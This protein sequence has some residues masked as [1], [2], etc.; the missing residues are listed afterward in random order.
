MT[1]AVS[2][3]DVAE[4]VGSTIRV[5][6]LGEADLRN[7]WASRGFSAAGRVVLKQRLPR[8]WRMAAVEL[9]LASAT[10]R[11]NEV[12]SRSNA[13]HLFSDHWPVRRWTAAWVAEQKTSSEPD[14]MFEQLEIATLD[15][16]EEQLRLLHPKAEVEPAQGA[17]CVGGIEKAALGNPATIAAAAREL[18]NAYVGRD[19]FVVP[20]L[21]VTG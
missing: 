21:E 8:T 17:I 7:W 9:D 6:R 15:Q 4:V 16:I 3:S 2:P 11:H 10:N 19:K 12:I 18:G 13:V 1:I 20:Y 14:I 5:A